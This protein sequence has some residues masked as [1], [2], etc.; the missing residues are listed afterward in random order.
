MP[1]TLRDID[2]EFLHDL[3]VAVR[4]TRS[5]L[6]LAGTCCPPAWRPAFAGEFKWLGDLTTP[7]RDLDVYLLGYRT[8][9]TGCCRPRRPSW[10]RST[11][12]WSASA[13][14]RAAADWSAGCAPARFAR[15]ISDWR[16]A[17]T[18][19]APGRGGPPAMDLAAAR[20]APGAPEG[21]APGPAIT[22]DSPAEQLH[23][24]RKRC[25][26]LRYLLEFFAS[27]FEPQAHQRAVKDLK[28]LQDCLGEFQDRQVQ[29]QE[30]REFAGQMMHGPGHAGHR[31]A[32]HGRAGGPAR[33]APAAG[34]A[35][36]SPGGSATSPARPASTGSAS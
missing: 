13:A 7:T 33:A 32:G 6:K 27:L 20:L 18:G 11:T 8:W 16:A 36:S 10:R 31:P 12:I 19:L 9:R 22:P 17:L 5:A 30:L 29:Q 26:E 2:T 23:D 35:A 34:P 15:L 14:N 24:L 21:A 25:K 28:G 1:G 3:R 4:R